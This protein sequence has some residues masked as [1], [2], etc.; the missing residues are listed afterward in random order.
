MAFAAQLKAERKRLGLTQP[1]VAALLARTRTKPKSLRK[2]ARPS[3][4]MA[5]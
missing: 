4:T 3:M 1:E 2:T 5:T